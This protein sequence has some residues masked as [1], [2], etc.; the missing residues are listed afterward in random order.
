MRRWIFQG[1]PERYDVADRR[2]VDEGKKETWL[3]TRYREQMHPGD[4]V[5]FWRAGQEE[6]KGLY[7]WGT[8]EGEPKYFQDW[9]WGVPIIY[10]KRFPHHLSATD[11]KQDPLLKQNLLFRMPIGTNFALTDEEASVIERTIVEKIG[12]DYASEG[13]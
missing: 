6:Q 5:Y 9:G 8:I 12:R 11:L 1:V 7:A 3:V 10:R 13:G 4:V 2:K